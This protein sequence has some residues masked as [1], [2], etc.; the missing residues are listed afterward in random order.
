MGVSGLGILRER[1][2]VVARGAGILSAM[3]YPGHEMGVSAS[4]PEES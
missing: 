4:A 3:I 1:P 2:V